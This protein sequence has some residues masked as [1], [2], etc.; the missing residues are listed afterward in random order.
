MKKLPVVLFLI[1]FS[2]IFSPSKIYAGDDF[3]TPLMLKE[4]GS[5]TVGGTVVTTPGKWDHIK[6][7]PEGQTL[8][9]DHAYVS[10]QVP[11]AARKYPIAFL[12]GFGQFSK[13]WET[14]PDGREGFNNIFLRRGYPVY[15]VDQPRRGD[16][17]RS[18]LPG[19]ISA[20]PDDQFWFTNF[21][22]GNWPD[23]FP[24][25]LFPNDPEALNQY[26]RQMTPNT[27]PFD[28]EVISDAIAKLFDKIGPGVL[29]T[30]SQGGGPGWLT[31]TKTDN[32][33][34]IV[35]YE[36]GSGFIFPEGE[37]PEPMPSSS[38]ALEPAAV[39]MEQFI[40]LT[41]MPIV[42][43]YGDYIP[44]EPS[45]VPG[46]D[47]WR[48]RLAMSRLW[49]K[50][51]NDKGGDVTVVHLPEVG[52]K[53][54]THFPFSDLNNIEIADLMENWLREKGIE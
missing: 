16:A 12:H 19:E 35:A 15:L 4:Q 51:V 28:A 20:I 40:K 27:G 52:I 3:Y 14:T 45:D 39:P 41:K 49:A 24:G 2:A 50:A 37:L 54:N 22:V 9:G 18:T 29:V 44:V 5:F 42:I 11:V 47:Q 33:A 8:H 38:G 13:T 7:G 48:V 21:R 36:P 46:P 1:I 25:V 6:R 31:A 17:G 10:Y 53:G 32:V 26:F 34:A 23:F 30:H 43:Y